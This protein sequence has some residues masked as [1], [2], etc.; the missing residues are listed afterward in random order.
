MRSLYRLHI[1]SVD[2]NANSL[3]N[4]LTEQNLLLRCAQLNS[5]HFVEC[6]DCIQ[7]VFFDVPFLFCIGWLCFGVKRLAMRCIFVVKT[8][9][10]KFL[11][12]W[13][14]QI[15]ISNCG[16]CKRLVKYGDVDLLVAMWMDLN[17]Q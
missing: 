10:Y 5:E 12:Q 2:F 9:I 7:A 1:W 11:M 8:T 17:R 14:S 4:L 6:N 3:L 15:K 13:L 16:D